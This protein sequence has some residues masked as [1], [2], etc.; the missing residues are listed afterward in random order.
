MN[1][2]ND[3][4]KVVG[5][6]EIDDIDSIE[7]GSIE[8]APAIYQAQIDKSYEIRLTVIGNRLFPAKISAKEGPAFLDWRP[9][10]GK[11]NCR[12]EAMSLEPT[13]DIRALQLIRSLGLAYG[14]IDLAVGNDG[15]TYF[16]EVNPRGQFLFIEQLVPEFPLLRAFTAMLSQSSVECQLDQDDSSCKM[17]DFERSD[18][19]VESEKKH[20][21]YDDQHF[22]SLVH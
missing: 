16:L 6:S 12:V 5:P 22:V 4:F 10:I 1:S 15:E 20:A 13:L 7:T 2:D 8:A 3:Q 21:N 9:A 17:S 18:E 11:P 19:F 14:C